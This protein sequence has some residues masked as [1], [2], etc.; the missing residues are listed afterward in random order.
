MANSEHIRWLLEGVESW[1]KRRG[2]DG[3]TPDLCGA[4]LY[5]EFRK[6]SNPGSGDRVPLAGVNLSR[7]NLIRAVLRRADLSGSNLDHADLT[8][9]NLE[10][11]R[12]CGAYANFV[13]LSDA[14]LSFAD[15]TNASMEHAI[16][17][18]ADLGTA[19]V[20]GLNAN[21]ANPWKANLYPMGESDQS[22]EQKEL[23]GTVAEDIGTLLELV[24]TAQGIHF[25]AALYFRG[26]SKCGWEMRPSV[27]R[28]EF[29][30]FESG[31]LR[32]LMSR[33][34]QEFSGITSAL[35]QWVLAQHHRL[36][37]R[38][39]DVT[40]NP[41][42]ALFFACEDRA[43]RCMDGRLHIIAVPP[44]LVKPFTSD[45]VSVVAN[46]GKLTENEQDFLLGKGVVPP[47]YP[48]SWLHYPEAMDRLC[49]LIQSEKPYFA[50]RI[51]IRDFFKVF[52]VE[53]Q[54]S[55]ER[56]RAQSG[57][58]LVSAFHE[59]FERDEVLKWNDNIPIYAHYELTIPRK[60][61]AGLVED[62]ERLNITR[63]T[64]FPGLDE[65]AAAITS[66]YS[67]ER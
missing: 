12:L 60:R 26:E 67:S 35:A 30:K 40:K 29:A 8:N 24:R 32:D 51:S 7:A 46:F 57:A 38:F 34:P 3:F 41:L 4:D 59:R 45:A 18:N 58:F 66:L 62:L 31:M 27:T 36:K 61:K 28:G 65:S 10:N 54:Q 50:N 11:G 64:L 63:E 19:I 39:L 14:N 15:L 47:G 16:L 20:T 49:Q 56:I 42:V 2:E 53:P 13:N 9:A 17:D 23:S 22:Q 43:F 6:S 52:V 21:G 1:N 33:R 5:E 25:G 37:T 48:N 55:A 44:L